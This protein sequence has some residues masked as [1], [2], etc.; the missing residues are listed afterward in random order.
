MIIA[1]KSVPVC[2]EYCL[3]LENQLLFLEVLYWFEVPNE[4]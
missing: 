4:N 3:E 1:A 2:Q